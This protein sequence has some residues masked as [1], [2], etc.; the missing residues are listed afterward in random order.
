MNSDSKPWLIVT[1]FPLGKT[2][3]FPIFFPHELPY[4]E[5]SV[6]HIQNNKL[7]PHF[8]GTT[9]L[10]RLLFFPKEQMKLFLCSAAPFLEDSTQ[11]VGLGAQQLSALLNS[12]GT[13]REKP[14][15]IKG[16]TLC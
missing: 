7:S 1:A 5:T 15:K 12:P 10:K 4:N 9:G 14:H 6:F 13:Q 2:P 8:S 11:C 3:T 16:R